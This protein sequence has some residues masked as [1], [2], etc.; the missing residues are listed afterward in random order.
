MQQAIEGITPIDLWNF[1]YTMLAIIAIIVCLEKIPDL[2]WKWKDRRQKAAEG[3]QANFAEEISEATM[4]K[5]EP[6]FAEINEKLKADK[7]RLDSHEYALSGM[8]RAQVDISEGF[9]VICYAMIAVLNH[10]IHNGNK[11]EMEEAL[12]R[13]HEYLS[14]RNISPVD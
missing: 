6:R 10:G 5:L 13:L 8:H 1:G 7:A 2:I 3:P 14:K 11:D 9:S 12:G 4:Q